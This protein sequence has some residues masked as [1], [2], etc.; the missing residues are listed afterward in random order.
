MFAA[1]RVMA[2]GKAGLESLPYFVDELLAQGITQLAPW[3]ADHDVE[4]IEKL[5]RDT[6]QQRFA[7]WRDI[8]GIGNASL[9][10][11]MTPNTLAAR[12]L[13][14][15]IN[16]LAASDGLAN[17]PAQLAA[18]CRRNTQQTCRD[19]A[20][21]WNTFKEQNGVNGQ[22]LAI[23]IPYCPEGPTSGTVGM[24]L[25]AALRKHFADI[26]QSDDLVVWG[27]ELCPPV[28]TDATGSLDKDAMEHAF[29]GY[30]AR[31][32]L[33]QGVPLTTKP[34]DTERYK[35]FDIN[36]V[37]DGGAIQSATGSRQR[38][39]QSIDRA[40]AQTTA[41]L[42]NGAAGADTAEA[43]SRLSVGSK[44]WNAHLTHV[45]SE[46]T[47]EQACRY[48]NYRVTLPWERSKEWWENRSTSLM[49]KKNDLQLRVDNYIRPL[50]ADEPDTAIKES[51]GKVVQ[52]VDKLAALKLAFLKRNQVR[53]I[54][55]FAQDESEGWAKQIRDQAPDK[56]TLRP[57]PFCL[58][59]RLPS[60][61]RRE[62]AEQLRDGNYYEP[63]AALLGEGGIS[64]V[65]GW[66]ETLLNRVLERSDC[67]PS[68]IASAAYFEEVIA[69]SIE[70]QTKRS[71]N[72]RF[73]PSHPFLTYFLGDETRELPGSFNT[74]TH[75]LAKYIP[76]K[77]ADANGASPK[78]KT[79][80]WHINGVEYDVPVE[81]TFLTLARCRSVDGFRDISTYDR[82]EAEYRKLTS[83]V[84]LWRQ[85]A[86]YY[87]VK[88]PAELLVEAPE[89]TV[90]EPSRNGSAESSSTE[91]T[92]TNGHREFVEQEV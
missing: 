16:P 36:I 53:S 4:E 24:Y 23:V 52:Q 46:S 26:R 90:S 13:L 22:Q 73:Q 83:N 5:N 76:P 44:R 68:Y 63:I 50:L 35:P 48:L 70:D 84:T 54:L 65:Q 8:H 57:D 9:G 80:Y 62:N 2:A 18:W 37:F 31:E 85:Y 29:R 12:D 82:L 69:V 67:F 71:D 17:S 78:P 45:V 33:L 86:K 43:A 34:D 25:G 42:L 88:P 21:L 40:A 47:Y 58:T 60:R 3:A 6:R 74:R 66:S 59:V 7:H 10:V 89:H 19:T 28:N 55:K 56:I 32:E 51:V 72:E 92:E 49:Q 91:G 11:K 77:A 1:A 38:I 15:L 20:R 75:D 27:I 79:L 41:S 39:W 64:E 30:V 61:L 81:Y 87:G 14:D